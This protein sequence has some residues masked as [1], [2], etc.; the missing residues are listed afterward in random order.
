MAIE[1]SDLEMR[2]GERKTYYEYEEEDRI[3]FG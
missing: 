1:C 3:E 2:R